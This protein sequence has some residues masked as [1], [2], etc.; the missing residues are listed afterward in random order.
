MTLFPANR[1]FLSI[2]SAA[3]NDRY[4]RDGSLAAIGGEWLEE[5]NGKRPRQG[6]RVGRSDTKDE[7][8][9]PSSISAGR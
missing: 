9:G 8:T 3:V 6:L 4:L 2:R 7:R 1:R 5:T